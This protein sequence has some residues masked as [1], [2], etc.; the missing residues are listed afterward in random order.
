MFV[1]MVPCVHAFGNFKFS[2]VSSIRFKLIYTLE[3]FQVSKELCRG[4]EISYHYDL[5]CLIMTS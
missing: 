2:I 4:P 5:G 1:F 3:N